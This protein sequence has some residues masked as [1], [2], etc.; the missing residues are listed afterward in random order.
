M[1]VRGARGQLLGPRAE[2]DEIFQHFQGVFDSTVAFDMPLREK[3]DFGEPEV[4]SAIQGLKG[5]KAV[6]DTSAPSELWQLCPG[7]YARFFSSIISASPQERE[8]LPP[9]VTD[10]TLALIPK[11]NKPSRRPADLRPLGLQDPGS[12]VLA[13]MV[14]GR[15]QEI[16]LGYPLARP[17]YAYCPTKATD[18]AI[19]HVARHC[20]AVRERVRSSVLSVRDRRAGRTTSHCVGGVMMSIDL[21][22]AFDNVPRWALQTALRKAGASNDLQQVVLALHEKCRCQV[23]HKG[24]EGT[25]AMKKGVRQGCAL[26]PH[27]YA[28]F[29]CLIFDVLAERTNQAW[30][31]AA[32]TLFADDS[33]LAWDVWRVEDLAFVTRCV[34]HTFRV[35]REFGMTV[36]PDKSQITLRLRGSAAAR[37]MR[38][39][40]VRVSGGGEVVELGSPHESLRIPRVSKMIYLGII[41]SYQGFGMQTCMHR[42]QAALVNRHRLARTLHCRQLT[43]TQRVRLYVACLRSSLLYGQHAVGTNMAV[44]RRQDQFDA[45]VLRAIAKTPSHLT[46]ESTQALRSRLRV[47][48]PMQVIIQTLTSRTRRA[49]DP[50]SVAWFAAHLLEL[51]HQGS[52]TQPADK[53]QT[54]SLFQEIGIPCNEC[55]QYFPSF[56]SMRS[57]KARKHDYKGQNKRQHAGVLTA[58]C[59]SVLSVKRFSLGLR[60]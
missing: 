23:K 39:H 32:M 9:E 55:G 46:R 22:R 44:L 7:A 28:L 4:L 5:G 42:Q 25:F 14:R 48:S 45:R 20:R 31:T 8:S 30:A 41:A 49:Q 1:R 52:L 21:S 18:E 53:E 29:S 11:P 17:Q 59:H 19:C 15:L 3:L 2:F 34:Q 33:H 60:A 10:C 51:Q 47:E 26:S 40:C 24:Y 38:K 12:K 56:R 50:S 57:H 43:M 27:L 54:T 58:A 37:W 36:N 6:P 16:T 13:M 35:F